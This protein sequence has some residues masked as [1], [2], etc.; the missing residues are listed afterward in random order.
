MLLSS[1]SLGFL[2]LETWKPALEASRML[3]AMTAA[4]ERWMQECVY[5]PKGQKDV[6]VFLGGFLCVKK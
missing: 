5:P 6:K 2:L 4:R 1:F 3:N